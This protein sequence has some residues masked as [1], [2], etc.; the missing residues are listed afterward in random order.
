MFE[1]VRDI[2]IPDDLDDIKRAEFLAFQ[3]SIAALEDEWQQIRQGENKNK[4]MCIEILD[5]RTAKRR[6][7]AEDRLKL[8]LEV[9]EKQVEKESERIESE[10]EE[11]KKILWTRLF[12]AYAQS[13]NTITGQL[14]ELMGKDSFQAYIADKATKTR[15]QLKDLIGKD[16]LQAYIADKS[17]KTRMQQPEDMKIKM[18][19]QECERD[20]KMIQAMFENQEYQQEDDE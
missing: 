17:M 11:A 2:P 20:L 13:E 9:I 8:R 19:P 7:Q 6:Q 18:T 5:E 4:R 10:N 14:K 3:E 12:H 16:S 1:S 15:M